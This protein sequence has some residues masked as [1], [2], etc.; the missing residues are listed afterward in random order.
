VPDCGA[1]ASVTAKARY[2]T[3]TSK[4]RK[5]CHLLKQGH[6]E[7]ALQYFV[8]L[9]IQHLQAAERQQGGLIAYFSKLEG[10]DYAE[11]GLYF[12]DTLADDLVD[13]SVYDLLR[14][15][16]TCLM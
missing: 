11:D 9:P 2:L 6:T 10:F 12:S 5:R 4:K 15:S 14:W 1:V 16:R 8:C 3:S 13:D 7:H